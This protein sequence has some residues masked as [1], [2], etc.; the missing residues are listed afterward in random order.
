ML[1]ILLQIVISFFIVI[2]ALFLVDGILNDVL[3]ETFSF[4]NNRMYRFVRQHKIETIL[5]IFAIIVLICSYS[6]LS[7]TTAYIKQIV[8]SI[9][10]VLNKDTS[11]VQLPD[12]FKDI[13][14]KL[15]TIKYDTLRHEQRAKE[16]EQHKNDLVVYLA[17][18][19]KTPLTS[20]IGYLTLLNE[21]HNLPNDLKEKY[22]EISLDKA[23]RLEN[24]INEFFEITRYNLTDMELHIGKVNLSVM[25]QQITDE[26]YP[27]LA[28]KQ[29]T[30]QARIIPEM[31]LQGDADKLARVFDNILR[32]AMNY[33]HPNTI[34]S[35]MA[36]QTE[37]HIQLSFTNQGDTIPAHKL[38]SI[39]EKFFRLDSSRSSKTG[40]AGL[41]LAITKEI[42]QLHHGRIS[43][44]SDS[45]YTRFTIL[46]PKQQPVSHTELS[47]TVQPTQM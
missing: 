4:L 9:D 6:T 44:E 20:V 2:V 33:S 45:G 14:N 26:F 39:F 31:I 24:L 25:L 7:K 17:H 1:Q 43:A 15:N 36:E 42:V 12:E 16:A 8:N 35:I 40:G 28:P 13:E 19:L 30:I 47:Q 34:I 23:N 18:D 29:L 3:A 38:K 27:L 41:G 10:K 11:L 21:S 46:L 5:V 37:S 32:N 22:L